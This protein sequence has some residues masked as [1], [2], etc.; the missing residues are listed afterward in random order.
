MFE[1]FGRRSDCIFLKNDEVL[2]SFKGIKKGK[3]KFP[4]KPEGLNLLHASKKEIVD[5]IVDKEK[6]VGLTVGFINSLR[7]KGIDFV[8]TFAEKNFGPTVYDDILSPY[9]LPEGKKFS[10][11]NEAIIYYFEG[12]NREEEERKKKEI[13]GKQLESQILKREGILIRLS[14]PEDFSIYRQKGDALLTYQQKVNASENKIFLDYLGKK[15]EIE[16]DTSLSIIENAEKYFELSKKKKRKAESE[17]KR[18]E[19]I[20]NELKILKKRREKLKNAEDLTEF[21]E[22]YSEKAEKEEAFPSKFRVFTTSN[23]SKV[24]VG[25]SAE[26]N[27]YLT[28][29]FARPFDI[30]LHV[31]NAPGS[32]TILRV[33]D[34]NKFPPVED[35]H[36]AA[37]Y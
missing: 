19:K 25:K 15:L 29:S 24:L 27:Q 30:F 37:Y 8:N 13:I 32:H 7:L 20:K 36:E 12:K 18:K 4:S 22:Y 31:K 34:K 10:T 16:I 28:F 3:Y 2:N 9:L 17:E 1:I 21:K 14:E 23:G 33:K 26:S 11:I 6:I 5:A 35:I